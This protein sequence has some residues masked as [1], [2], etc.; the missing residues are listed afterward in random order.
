MKDLNSSSRSCS[1]AN[2]LAQNMRAGKHVSFS[3][4]ALETSNLRTMKRSNIH[5]PYCSAGDNSIVSLAIMQAGQKDQGTYDCCIKNSYGKLTTEFN[6]TAEGKPRR[7]SFRRALTPLPPS[8]ECPCV[9]NTLSA[10]SSS[11][12]T[13]HESPGSER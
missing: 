13:T 7:L 2:P 10:F 1:L 3:V 12:E 11:S 6:L 5:A 8:S 9:L 4:S